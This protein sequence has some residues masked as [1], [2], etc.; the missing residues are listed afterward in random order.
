MESDN[1]FDDVELNQV[2]RSMLQMTNRQTTAQEI[3]R[4]N[5]NDRVPSIHAPRTGEKLVV[6]ACLT[7]VKRV[8][9][10]VQL[11]FNQQL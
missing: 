11:L 6:A 1:T 8:T 10:P 5:L 9:L 2:I 7:S 3:T 4:T